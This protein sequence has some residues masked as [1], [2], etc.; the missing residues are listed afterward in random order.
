MM[1][2]VRKT[3]FIADPDGNIHEIHSYRKEVTNLH[4][5]IDLHLSFNLKN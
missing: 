1:P 4:N 5:P 2:W 3:A